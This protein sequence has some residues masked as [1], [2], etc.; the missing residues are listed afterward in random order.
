MMLFF[1]GTGELRLRIGL[2]GVLIWVLRDNQG[3]G[4]SELVTHRSREN[5]TSTTQKGKAHLTQS[6][7][8]RGRLRLHSGSKLKNHADVNRL[9]GKEFSCA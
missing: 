2:N 1:L 3:L 8:M 9:S 4:I 6:C 7:M 5:E